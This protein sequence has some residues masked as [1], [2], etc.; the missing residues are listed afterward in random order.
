[1]K[2]LKLALSAGASMALCA[3][4]FAAPMG[5]AQPATPSES[6]TSYGPYAGPNNGETGW[7]RQGPGRYGRWSGKRG[8]YGRYGWNRGAMGPYGCGYGSGCGYGPGMMGGYGWG[9]QGFLANQAHRLGLTKEQHEKIADIWNG[10]MTQ[11]WPIMGQ[12][13]QLRFHMH[14]LMNSGTVNEDAVNRTY[15]QMATLQRRLLDIRL[16]ARTKMLDVLTVRQRKELQWPQ[17]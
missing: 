15:E 9:M 6:A 8:G 14:Q 5:S 11:A 12:L 17:Y 10:A 1:M 3:A 2:T 16:E 7:Q 4:L 13:R